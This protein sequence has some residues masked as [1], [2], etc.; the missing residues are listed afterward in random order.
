M[1]WAGYFEMAHRA[2]V[3][4]MLDDVQFVRSWWT[5]RNR[6]RKREAP[7]WQWVTAQVHHAP[8]KSLINSI[9]LTYEK[10]WRNRIVESLR[11]MY[12]RSPY[13][14]TYSDDISDTLLTDFDRLADLNLAIIR[15]FLSLLGIQDR[16]LQSSTLPTEGTRD[17]KLAKICQELNADIY[18]ANNGAKSYIEPEKF[19]RR[20]IGFVFQ[21]YE[22]PTYDQ[23][24]A[25]F[26]SHLSVVDLLFWHGPAAREILLQGRPKDWL[27]GVNY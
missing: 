22:H 3:F 2:D 8:Q 15:L 20:D 17:E 16:L 14:K 5:N 1:P 6:I 25:P 11:R 24:G 27:D 10:R 4:V 19:H 12:G 18:L 13:F 26:I 21:D 23:G 7:N 9:K